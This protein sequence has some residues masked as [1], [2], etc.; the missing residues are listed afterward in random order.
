[1]K[2]VDWSNRDA[3]WLSVREAVERGLAAVAPLPAEDVPLEEALG[4]VLAEDVDAAVDQPPWDNS[5]MDGFA[6]RAEDVRGATADHP[7]RLTIVDDIPAG[8]FPSRALG[9]GEAARIMTGAPTPEG[10]DSVVRVEHT[11]AG[12]R[13]VEIRRDRDA[14]GNIR[15]RGEDLA[16]GERAQIGRAHV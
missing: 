10:A 16:A 11:D 6:A 14:G 7:V 2:V 3:D 15:R 5:A 13:V 1:M 9:P 12:E 8:G 4:R